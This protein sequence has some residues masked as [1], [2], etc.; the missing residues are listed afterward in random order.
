[1]GPFDTPRE[2]GGVSVE[3][4]V[5]QHLVAVNDLMRLGYKTYYYRTATGTEVDF[6]M[7]GERG[8]IAIEVKSSNTYKP[9]MVAG[10]KRFS[11]DYPEAKLYLFY[12]GEKKLY[13]NNI[14]VLPL[15]YA[16]HHLPT[17]LR[18]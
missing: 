15:T 11:L 1:M 2:I 12:T 13:I 3:T 18:H 8:I 14:T 10:L 17:L 6:V 16:L 7:Y 5:C 4:L 9:E